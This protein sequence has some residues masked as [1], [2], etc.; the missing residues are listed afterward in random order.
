MKQ[1]LYQA[2][3]WGVKTKSGAL[4]PLN[5][6]TRER[7]RKLCYKGAKPVKILV[8][9]VEILPEPKEPQ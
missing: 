7:A 2:E 9:L 1:A 4:T 5:C 3:A 8:T 6:T